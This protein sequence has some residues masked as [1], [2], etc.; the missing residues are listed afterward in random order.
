MIGRHIR[1]RSE[2]LSRQAS[3][4][5]YA[6]PGCGC[7]RLEVAIGVAWKTVIEEWKLAFR[8]KPSTSQSGILQHAKEFVLE[9]KSA[10]TFWMKTSRSTR[11][12]LICKDQNKPEIRVP[13]SPRR[14]TNCNASDAAR[15]ANAPSSSHGRTFTSNPFACR[16]NRTAV[17]W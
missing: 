3:F 6:A 4:S 10:W 5:W 12:S 15:H 14:N 11:G 8:K 2:H 17:R 1:D 7:A 16:R 13:F 9:L